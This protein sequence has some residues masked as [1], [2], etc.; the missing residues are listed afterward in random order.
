MLEIHVTISQK[1]IKCTTLLITL[2]EFDL[3]H[4]FL[5]HLSTAKA[6]HFA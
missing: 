4:Y 5:Y 1:I 3:K 6:R 2:V